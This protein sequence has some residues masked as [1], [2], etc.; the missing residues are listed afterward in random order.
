MPGGP[1]PSRPVSR[2]PE[3]GLTRAGL[4]AASRELLNRGNRRNPDV[5]LVELAGERVVVKDFAPRGR[6]VRAWLGRWIAAREARAYQRRSTA[7]PRCRAFAA[8]STGSPSRS[9][10]VPA[11]GSRGA[12]PDAARRL[13]AA[14]R[15]GGRARCTRAASRTST[16]ATA[17]TCS[18]AEDGS[19]VLIDFGVGGLLPARGPRRALAAAAAR[20]RRPRRARQV[21]AQARPPGLRPPAGAGRRDV[22][23]RR[24]E[25]EP[26]DVVPE[27]LEGEARVGHRAVR[28]PV[29]STSPAGAGGLA[30]RERGRGLAGDERPGVVE[31]RE[32]DH[33]VVEGP[34]DAARLVGALEERDVH[35]HVL[36]GRHDRLALGKQRRRA[37]RAP[38]ARARPRGPRP[39]RRSPGA[40]RPRR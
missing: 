29:P 38:G 23:G 1:L 19:P 4:A 26:P 22:V 40:R 3:S 28:A 14:P 20:A 21:A 9:S 36:T 34:G 31:R 30:Q 32:V 13:P 35:P 18:S 17:A 2:R 5:L 24:A 8:G 33:V 16:C 10:T 7:T 12:S 6:L 27:G 25:R 11:G 37:R 39:R 15:G